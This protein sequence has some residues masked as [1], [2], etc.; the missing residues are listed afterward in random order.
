V[1]I[2]LHSNMTRQPKTYFISDLH[3]TPDRPDVIIA[4][5]DFLRYGLDDAEKLYI[6][7]D[8]F[9]YWIGD[10]AANL[11][12]AR[13]ILERMH[14]VANKIPCF[15]IAGNRDFLVGEEFSSRSGFQIIEDKSLIDLYGTN[16]LLLHGDSLCTDDVAHQKFRRE[17]STNKKWH[18]DILCLTIRER[19]KVATKARADSKQHKSQVSMK[20]MDVTEDAVITAFKQANVTQMIHGHTHRQDVHDYLIDDKACKRYVL[21]DWDQ[22]A[23][24]MVASENGLQINNFT[25]KKPRPSLVLFYFRI[26]NQA[27]KL[28]SFFNKS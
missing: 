12:G 8:L 27:I 11:L 2:K 4:F 18:D 17:I 23:S 10:D 5:F 15:F 1:N 24:V 6:L 21:G 3:L 9:E 16:T 13:L 22:S 28:L 7:G 20:I 19:I 25:I 26:R 14:Q